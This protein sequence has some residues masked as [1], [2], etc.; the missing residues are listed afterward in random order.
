MSTSKGVKG[1]EDLKPGMVVRVRY[2]PK[3]PF[4]MTIHVRAVVEGEIMVYRRWDVRGWKYDSKDKYWVM[5]HA[6]HG[7]LT[8]IGEEKV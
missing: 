1:I 3:N 5:A 4:N 2:R 7:Y 8:I 6:Q